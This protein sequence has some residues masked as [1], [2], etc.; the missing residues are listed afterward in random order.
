MVDAGSAYTE[1]QERMSALVATLSAAQLQTRVP[2]CPDWTVQDL[3]AH[4]VGA[5][6]DVGM[7]TLAELGD[8]ARLLDQNSDADVARDRDAMTGRQVSDRRG[9][10]IQAVLEEWA[11]ATARI[12]PMLQGD[13]SFPEAVGFVGGVIAVNDIVIHEGDLHEALGLEGPAVVHAT[14]LAL[15]GYGFSLD[16]RVK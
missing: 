14:S 10:S 3:V 6:T 7:G 16:H 12:V 1:V 15:A 11:E 2:A 4:H 8:L 13:V 9:R 5:M